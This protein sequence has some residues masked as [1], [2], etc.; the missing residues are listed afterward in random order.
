MSEHDPILGKRITR[1]TMLQGTALAG[2]GAFLAACGTPAASSS[3]TS[4]ADGDADAGPQRRGHPGPHREADAERRPQLRQLA[5]L[6]RPGREQPAQEPHPGAVHGEVRHE[7]QL[8]RGDQRQRHVL[9]HDPAAPPGRPGHRLGHRRP[10]RLDG[11][12][13]HPPRLGRDDR[14]GEH[15]QLRG[16]PAR[17]L[18]GRRVGSGHEAAGA[19][20]VRHDRA[21]L[22]RGDDRP[23]HEPGG[24]VDRRRP[25]EGPGLVP[26][27]DARHRGPDPPQAGLQVRGLHPRPGGRGV[28]RDPEGR[29]RRDRPQLP[30]ERL[31]GGPGQG[32]PRPGDR[33][34]RR[35]HPGHPGE[36]HP[37]VRDPRRGRA[38]LD[39]QHADPQGGPA[40]VHGRAD[41]RLG[42]RPGDRGPDGRL[43]PVRLA[44]S[45]G[46]RRPWRR[47]PTRRSLPWPRTRSC[48]PTT[49]P[50]RRCTSSRASTRPRRP[51]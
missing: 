9:R 37:A 31:Q 30:R 35:H 46:P 34:V 6:H 21:R 22:R 19:L 25:L 47:T 29:R 26:V 23:P 11:L 1:R 33:M 41:D 50:W 32:R 24:A 15:A 3:P 16:Q 7:G 28:R 42:L 44:R 20:A 5:P 40:Q 13:P 49:R 8:R 12:A 4:G 17:R 39:R 18:Q 14:H 36:G 51:T 2:V 38:A 27:R 10:D 43:D 48:S 45:R